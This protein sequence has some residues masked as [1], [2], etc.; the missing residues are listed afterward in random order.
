MN[1]KKYLPTSRGRAEIL[2]NMKHPAGFRCWFP[3]NE[4]G[5]IHRKIAMLKN[6]IHTV[7][8]SARLMEEWN[9]ILWKERNLIL[10]FRH[11]ARKGR[12]DVAQTWEEMV[13]KLYGMTCN[14]LADYSEIKAFKSPE[15]L[16]AHCEPVGT[17]PRPSV[18]ESQAE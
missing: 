16:D 18:Q 2:I 15:D 3:F 4:A 11:P 10:D 9:E 7:D 1:I 8:E 14:A 12:N 6:F 13:G 5:N 17:E